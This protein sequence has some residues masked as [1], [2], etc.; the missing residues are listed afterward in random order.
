MG[1]LFKQN[2]LYEFVQR[3][4]QSGESQFK[5]SFIFTATVFNAAISLFYSRKFC[6]SSG[7]LLNSPQ[8]NTNSHFATSASAIELCDFFQGN[9]VL[10]CIDIIFPS[11][12][13]ASL[14]LA[15]VSSSSLLSV[16]SS[17]SLNFNSCLISSA[18]LFTWAK[19]IP[20]KCFVSHRP[21][22]REGGSV[23]RA[24]KIKI[25]T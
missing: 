15:Q 19:A 2:F 24:K 22:S 20:I 5:T 3:T 13:D 16:L 4:I 18:K 6:F 23:S 25:N 7:C 12:D 21:P 14:I 9:S 1:K 8:K 11:T 10:Q 17:S